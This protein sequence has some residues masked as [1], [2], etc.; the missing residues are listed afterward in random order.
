MTSAILDIDQ[1]HIVR[2]KSDNDHSDND[3]LIVSWFVGGTLVRTDT[4]ALL[5]DTAAPSVILE[6]GHGIHPVSSQVSCTDDD[7]VTAS[8]LV[9]NL[10]STDYSQQVNAAGQ[11]AKSVSQE[12]AKVYL[13]VAEEYVKANPEIP[14]NEV[15]AW[16]IHELSPI[17][18]DSVGAAWDDI[19]LPAVNA[20]V[21]ELQILLGTPNC[22]GEVFHDLVVFQP[23]EPGAPQTWGQTYRAPRVTGCGSAA[24]TV[25]VYTA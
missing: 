20:I 7:L 18:V 11:I 5:N 17:I 10:G 15:W 19:I 24:A 23:S 3:W 16:A 8:I 9:V 1:M 25:V 2:K 13:R 4:Q 22:N 14:L 6:T 12:L 21:E